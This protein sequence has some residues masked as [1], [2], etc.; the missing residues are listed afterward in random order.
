MRRTVTLLL[1][2]C[3]LG[4]ISFGALGAVPGQDKRPPQPF[5]PDFY[6]GQATLQ[7]APAP[8]GVQLVACVYGCDTGF[9]S[10]P[11]E[12][13]A[14]GRYEMLEVDPLDEALIGLPINFYLINEFGRV[15][16][17]E[18]PAYEGIYDFYD[19]DLTFADPPAGWA[20]NA[21]A[22]AD[23][24]TTAN[25]GGGGGAH[26]DCG[27]HGNSRTDCR[28]GTRPN[29][30]CRAARAGRPGGDRHS[31][32]GPNRRRHRRSRRG[33]TDTLGPPPSC[34]ITAAI[35]THPSFPAKARPQPRSGP[36]IQGHPSK[37]IRP[38]AK[39][40]RFPLSRE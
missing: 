12:I 35:P 16:A 22:F 5:F 10:Q 18:S 6:S 28:P 1:L 17:A 34:K 29:P 33:R 36:G 23:A 21:R 2:F 20:A 39:V 13:Q 26:A 19:Q 24:N 37:A 4:A 11:V 38:V 9:Q 14:G 40:P 8:A 31:T 15:E 7:G 27:S 25:A 3:T 30:H 32:L